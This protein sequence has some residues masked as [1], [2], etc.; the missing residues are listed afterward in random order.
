MVSAKSIK[1]TGRVQGVGFRPFIYQLANIYNL[2]GTV[3]NNMDGVF[4]V[5]EG[6]ENHLIRFIKEIKVNPPKLSRID[7]IITEEISI[8]HYT[9]FHIIPSDTAG[10]QSL[11]IPTDAA[12]CE[13]C[14]QEMNDS[15][16]FRYQYPFINCTQCGPRYTIISDIPYDRPKTS[17]KS[18]TMCN[19]CGEEY[20]DPMNR[21]HHAQPIACPACGPE[22]QLLS[23]DGK[24][25]VKNQGAIEQGRELLQEGAIIAIK[26]IGGYH[27]A[28]N[29]YDKQAI[30]KLRLRKNRPFRPLAVM[31][32]SFDIITNHCCVD[33]KEAELLNSSVAP[34]VLLKQ[35]KKQ[36]L[37]ENIAPA[38]N[39]IG[40]MLPYT[41]LHH[42]LLENNNLPLIVLTSANPSSMPIL[43][44]DNLALDYLKGLAD[45]ILTHNREILHPLDDSVVQVMDDRI[46]II[47]RSRGYVPDPITTNYSVHQIIAMGSQ[48][49]NT[50]AIGRHQQIFL[51][52]YIG[53]MENKEVV[54]FFQHELDHFQELIGTIGEIYVIDKHPSYQTRNIVNGYN[55]PVIAVQHHHAHHVACMED[56][57]LSA[58]SFGIILDGSG[59]G[60]DG[61][62]WGFEFLYGN[63][64]F[65]NRLAHLAYTPLP[66][67]EKAI[68]EPWRNAV[69]MVISYLGEEAKELLYKIFPDKKGE[70]SI[71]S[72][73]VDIQLN[74]P[75]A[76]TCGRLFD[77][78]SAILDIC[79]IS[80]YEG[81]AAIRISELMSDKQ[82]DFSNYSYE[83]NENNQE[84]ELNFAKM[85]RQIIYDYLQ[86]KPV[87]DIVHTFH[88]TI[89]V[90]ITDMMIKLANKYPN[91]NREV[92]LSGGSFH[93]P[94]LLTELKKQLNN[95][96]FKVFS[97]KQVPTNDNGLALGQIIIAASR[98]KESE[99]KR[100]HE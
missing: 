75:L 9:S 58:P 92:V 98:M 16:N 99:E 13:A 50:F 17:M 82:I 12:S 35:N 6:S 20:E 42:L 96:G 39:T 66:G 81:E 46:H 25:L 76:G 4:I 77:A 10:K 30:A 7:T 3:Q 47:R 79:Q 1:V 40:V 18:F 19:R 51:G 53:N 43:Y 80:T 97:H 54:H 95:H 71:L 21:R 57:Q 34:I 33:Q 56:N 62:I 69:G 26:G 37:P 83:I 29:A 2:K 61:H 52:P 15:K 78:V 5:V 73:M 28:C 86:E 59:Y 49:K 85:L 31:A 55:K 67:G 63:A 32:A 24:L 38:V 36:L 89:V 22:V 65:I 88:Q 45:Y 23:M 74:T 91:Y 70:I 84:L 44:Q 48:Q 100:R 8:Q 94:Y 68:M 60:D 87:A 93:N 41:P 14:I 64:S 72:K 11:V 27:L 90:A